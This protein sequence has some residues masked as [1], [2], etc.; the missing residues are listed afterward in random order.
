MTPTRSHVPHDVIE[1][2]RRIAAPVEIVFK[3]FTDP[4][5]YALWQGVD[6]ELDPRPGGIFRVTIG[7]KSQT[8]ARGVYLEVH[9]P[10]RVSFTWGWEGP[11]PLAKGQVEIPPGTTTVEVH[12]EP[13]GDETVLRLRH[14][15]LPTRGVHA[16]HTYGW[17][18]TLDRLA[19]IATGADPG[20][21][22]FVDL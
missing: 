18:Y 21:N 19:L 7:G 13:D 15:G 1:V 12:L 5:R 4:E 3:Y 6:A 14:G 8:V 17:S 22:P 9:P 11:E 20:P 10:T 2:E 16:F